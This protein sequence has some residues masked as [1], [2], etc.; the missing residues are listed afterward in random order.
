MKKGVLLFLISL[1]LPLGCLAQAV[2]PGAVLLASGHT[3]CRAGQYTFFLQ[4]TPIPNIVL[5]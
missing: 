2:E 4:H 5:S 1:A 3:L